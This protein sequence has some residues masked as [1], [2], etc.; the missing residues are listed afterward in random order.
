MME[1][2]PGDRLVVGDAVISVLDKSGRATRIC[3]TSPADV[4][5]WKRAAEPIEKTPP[6]LVDS[7]SS[8]TQ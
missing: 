5:I 8:M 4:P 2:R 3:V 6:E 1:L 7:E